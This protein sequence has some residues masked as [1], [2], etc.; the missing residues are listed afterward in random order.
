MSKSVMWLIGL[1][2]LMLGWADISFSGS[3]NRG[4]GG[5]GLAVLRNPA[6]QS[7]LN[8]AAIAYV[9][10]FR[11][12]MGG[13]DV[14]V[15]GASLNDLFDAL[16]LRQ[17]SAI[18]IDEGARWL[19]RFADEDTS[20]TVTGDFGFIINGF[21]ISVGGVVEA[22]FLANAPLRNWA[23]SSDDPSLIPPDSRGDI[24]AIAAVSLPDITGGIRLPLQGGELAI[25]ARVRT[26]R[27]FYTHYFADGN[28]LRS[29]D[30]ATRAAELGGR[31]FLERRATGVDLGLIWKPDSTIPYTIA[32]VVENAVEPDAR[33]D[34]TDRNDNPVRLQPLRRAVHVGFAAETETGTLFALDIID[35]GNRTGRGELRIGTEQRLGPLRIRSGY[36]SRTGWTAGLGIGGF[37]FAY[38]REFPMQVSRSLVF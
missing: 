30:T 28:T 15:R 29:G 10:G 37:N 27:V 12:G 38:S 2:M 8:P 32:L 4:M 11:L 14:G 21:G 1:L 6:A 24:I 5:A 23:R 20:L 18:D 33:F 13:F 35:V 22:R 7:Y 31:D 25:G 17:G 19:R 36:A 9:R 26:M 34:A 16:K 3:A